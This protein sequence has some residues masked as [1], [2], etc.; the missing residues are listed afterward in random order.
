[1]N[2]DKHIPAYKR[3]E[4]S[5]FCGSRIM[6]MTEY[7]PSIIRDLSC[8]M[9]E[10]VCRYKPPNSLNRLLELIVVIPIF[11]FAFCLVV[12]GAV[13][14]AS[15]EK[16]EW[17]IEHSKWVIEKKQRNES[18]TYPEA[19]KLMSIVVGLFYGVLALT[20]SLLFYIFLLSLYDFL[21]SQL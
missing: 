13:Y 19:N 5:D 21:I 6:N 16:S 17:N 7:Q 4:F 14:S 15:I 1:M 12:Y 8:L 11:P 20:L 3:H 2:S 9:K 18:F 10:I